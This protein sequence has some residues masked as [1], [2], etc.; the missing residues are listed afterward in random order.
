[1]NEVE[2]TD[3][4]RKVPPDVAKGI[5]ILLI[6]MG[7]NYLG[8]TSWGKQVCRF[9]YAFHVPLFFF[10]SGWLTNQNHSWGLISAA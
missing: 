9:V 8:Y 6:V 3:F 1:M 7:H 2:D 4:Y 5:G 10:I